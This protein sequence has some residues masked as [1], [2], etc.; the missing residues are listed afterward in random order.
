MAFA[1]QS[2][3]LFR[4]WIEVITTPG[5]F[6][7]TKHVMSPLVSSQSKLRLQGSS[8]KH[9]GPNLPNR[10]LVFRGQRSEATVNEG[11]SCRKATSTTSPHLYRII[12]GI[13]F[14]VPFNKGVDP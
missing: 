1:Y 9:F 8:W 3:S 13:V 11:F 12:K 5:F 6:Y 14:A 4:F 10:F 2:A 7:R